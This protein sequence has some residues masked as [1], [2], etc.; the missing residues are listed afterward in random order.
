MFMRIPSISTDSYMSNIAQV[1]VS[2]SV[3]I[4][5]LGMRLLCQNNWMKSE[6]RIILEY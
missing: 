2:I 1:T 5:F 6:L 3:R 4:L